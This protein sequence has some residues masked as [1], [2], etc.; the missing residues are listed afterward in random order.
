AAPTSPAGRG[1]RRWRRWRGSC[2]RWTTRRWCCPA[3]GPPP[4]SARSGS[5]TPTSGSWPD[6][7]G[8]RTSIG[9]MGIPE[10]VKGAPD[11]LPPAA[12]TFDAVEAAFLDTARRAGYQRIRTPI[13]EHTEVFARGVGESTDIVQKEMY[14]F[15]DKGGRSLTLRPEGT[16]GVVRAALQAGVPRS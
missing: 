15:A 7:G 3:T 1:T 6:T 10:G 12:A 2:C 14:T 16:A 4:P 13:F 8:G 11:W 5:A 9:A